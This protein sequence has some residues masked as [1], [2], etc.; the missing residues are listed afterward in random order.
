MGNEALAVYMTNQ[1]N[2][3]RPT[4]TDDIVPKLPPA[5]F[6]FVHASPEYWITSGNNVTVTT[7]D[8]QE[9]QGVGSFVGNAGTLTSE[10]APHNWYIVNIDACP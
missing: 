1:G 6:G 9:I 5:S 4:H 2:L 7:A 8:I 3:W 10:V